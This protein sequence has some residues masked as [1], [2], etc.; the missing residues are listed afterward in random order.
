MGVDDGLERFCTARRRDGDRRFPDRLLSAGCLGSDAH[1]LSCARRQA[2]HRECSGERKRRPEPR[3]CD[4]P[5]SDHRSRHWRV[6]LRRRPLPVHEF[7][8]GRRSHQSGRRF[9]ILELRWSAAGG[10]CERGRQIPRGALRR[11]VDAQGISSCARSR[12][13]ARA[14][15]RGAAIGD[16]QA[17]RRDAEKRSCRFHSWLQQHIQG[18]RDGHG[19]YLPLPRT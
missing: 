9:F 12:R 7:R 14:S 5:S 10:G 16:S 1:H 3:L 4:G 15:G 18:C 17:N 13:R 11:V 19:K 8:V 6:V 2:D